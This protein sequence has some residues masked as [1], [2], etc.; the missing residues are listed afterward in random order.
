MDDGHCCL[1]L[2]A[3]CCRADCGVV[4]PCSIAHPAVG[5]DAPCGNRSAV[6]CED[7]ISRFV[8]RRSPCSR[9]GADPD[10]H[11]VNSTCVC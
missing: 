6:K 9:F 4:S 2:D 8:S 10:R 3:A 11:S 1:L 5:S 7:S